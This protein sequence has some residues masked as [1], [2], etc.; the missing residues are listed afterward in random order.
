[1]TEIERNALGTIQCLYNFLHGIAMRCVFQGHWVT[2]DGALTEPLTHCLVLSLGGREG[3]ATVSTEENSGSSARDH[4]IKGSRSQ[5][6]QQS[7]SF[8]HASPFKTC[9]APY[10]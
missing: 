9:P 2:P 3:H 7:A 10:Q 1:M 8:L 5:D 6:L 4:F